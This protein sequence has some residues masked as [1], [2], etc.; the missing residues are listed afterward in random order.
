MHAL[1]LGQVLPLLEAL[2]T[3]G[4]FEWLLARVDAAVPL[5]L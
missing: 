5:Q 4:A 2:V 3:V 1:V